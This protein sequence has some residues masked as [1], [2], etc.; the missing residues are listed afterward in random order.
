[1]GMSFE[2][3]ACSLLS[4]KA[5]QNS[6]YFLREFSLIFL[7]RGVVFAVARCPYVCPSVTLVHCIHRAE[8]IVK[9]LSQHRSAIILVFSTHIIGTQFQGEPYSWEQ[10]TRGGKIFAIFH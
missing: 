5:Q 8:D 9:L 3:L 10:S 2:M 4:L 1:M 6:S 7:R